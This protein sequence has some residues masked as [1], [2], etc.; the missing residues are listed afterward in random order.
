MKSTE[1]IET[2]KDPRLEEKRKSLALKIYEKIKGLMPAREAKEKVKGLLVINKIIKEK[3]P[4]KE[5]TKVI[6][7]I[8]ELIALGIIIMPGVAK[9]EEAPTQQIEHVD[10]QFSL[11]PEEEQIIVANNDSE[12]A[13]EAQQAENRARANEGVV[14]PDTEQAEFSEAE[15]L[16][17][18]IMA[19]NLQI[20]R[21]QDSFGDVI[22]PDDDP[23]FAQI[24]KLEKERNKLQAQLNE[25]QN[26]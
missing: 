17:A 8:T 4:A 5:A 24:K 20:N 10:D 18:R 22:P 6:R 3:L 15:V 26:K 19:I 11:T 23:R 14:S 1:K 25:L 9:A 12:A 13:W 16:Q 7:L 21:I 2:K